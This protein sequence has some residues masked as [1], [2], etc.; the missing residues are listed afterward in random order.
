MSEFKRYG[1]AASLATLLA[2]GLAGCGGSKEASQSPKVVY[3]SV[4]SFGD[5]LSDP[6]AYKVGPIAGLG[7][8]LF[9]VN[10]IAGDVGA[11]PTPSY[12]WAQLVS[13]A[14]IGKVS[15]AARVGFG[16]P[17]T[18]VPGCTNYAQGGSRITDP[19]GTGKDKGALTEPVVL[20]VNNYLGTT[21]NGLFTGNELVTVQGGANE[22][23]FQATVL[24][25]AAKAEGAK[26][27][28]STYATNLVAS[29][30]A[31]A[32]NPT[33]AA[34]AIGLA[35]ATEQARAGSTPETITQAAIV[36][37]AGQP[38]N[39][40]VAGNASDIVA[41][42]TSAATTAGAAAGARYAATTGAGIAV[43][44]LT[45]A[46]AELSAIVKNMVT[47]GAKRIVVTNL[48][49]VSQTPYALGTITVTAGVAD[50]S[51]QQL[52][53]AMTKAFNDKLKA[54]LAGVAGVLF[55]DVF[56]EY[57][58]QI[59]NPAQYGLSNVKDTAC[60]LRLPANK[61]ATE[62][63]AD[64]SSLVCKPSN[65][66]AGDTSRY[67]FADDVHPTP[68]GHKLLAQLVNK[69]LILAGWL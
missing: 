44:G 10:G 8:G 47:K 43:T 23:F 28:A 58:K 12:T 59:A 19:A 54:D 25:A 22:L 34:Q 32:T 5:S 24:E 26:V 46:A 62:G 17:A 67:L 21:S 33:T 16:V 49:D 2:L 57:Q 9:T 36:A 60:D 31:G 6:G 63:K 1:L 30:A 45:T 50:N 7:G 39:A 27:G 38:G 4:V 52:I 14:A 68:Y 42:A 40:A 3:S 29:L 35:M 65:L 66:I 64:G 15:C 56:T 20:Q 41:A 61:L 55:V 51:T 18:P 37:A 53:L 11:D 48:P 13:A 69:E